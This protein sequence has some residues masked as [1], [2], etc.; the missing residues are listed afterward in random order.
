MNRIGVH[1]TSPAAIAA[2]ARAFGMTAAARDRLTDDQIE[3]LTDEADMAV[4][5]ERLED[6]K[7]DM[8]CAWE[9]ARFWAGGLNPPKLPIV[10]EGKLALLSFPEVLAL[11]GETNFTYVALADIFRGASPDALQ[12]HLRGVWVDGYCQKLADMGWTA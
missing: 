6:T 9:R 11:C 12:L 1:A 4:S 10:A 5:T 3:Q 7:H 2:A 8:H